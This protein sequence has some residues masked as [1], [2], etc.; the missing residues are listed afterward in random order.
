MDEVLRKKI[1]D[2]VPDTW[3]DPLLTGPHK[4]IAQPPTNNDIERVCRGIR[5]RLVAVCADCGNS[6]SSDK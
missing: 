1:L 3:L 2:C 5:D 4:V 6:G